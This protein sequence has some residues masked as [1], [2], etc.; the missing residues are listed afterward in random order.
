MTAYCC[1]VL[2][3]I[4]KNKGNKRAEKTTKTGPGI[5][6]LQL[7]DPKGRVLVRHTTAS[8]QVLVNY[9]KGKK[10]KII[11]LWSFGC[12]KHKREHT[13]GVPCDA[14]GEALEVKIKIYQKKACHDDKN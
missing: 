7:N 14:Y 11:R 3:F 12:K 8:L 13:L 2:L 9:F 10:K 4:M 1:H 5:S 6:L